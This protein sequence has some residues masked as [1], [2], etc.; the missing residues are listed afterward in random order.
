MEEDLSQ[1][2]A[3]KREVELVSLN[4][5]I[6]PNCAKHDANHA[7]GILNFVSILLYYYYIRASTSPS[8]DTQDPLTPY[9]VEKSFADRR[10]KVKS[11]RTYFYLNESQCE[12]NMETFLE[13]LEA[14]SGIN[15]SILPSLSNYYYYWRNFSNF[16]H[17]Q[18]IRV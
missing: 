1:E 18:I 5:A 8:A 14:V 10:Y 4:L 11:A 12:R 15:F 13:C 3:E 6:R 17:M 2:E 7:I 16:V 9:H